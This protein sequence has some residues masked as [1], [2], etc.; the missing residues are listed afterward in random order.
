MPACDM[1]VASKRT[2]CALTHPLQD[3]LFADS[4]QVAITSSTHAGF[5]VLL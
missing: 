3:A 2:L 4:T 5:T 1:L